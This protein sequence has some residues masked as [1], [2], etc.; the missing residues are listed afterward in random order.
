MRD[1]RRCLWNHSDSVDLDGHACPDD[2]LGNCNLGEV[3]KTKH[4]VSAYCSLGAREW[5][6]D[7]T[8]TNVVALE[9]REIGMLTTQVVRPEVKGISLRNGELTLGPF[10]AGLDLVLTGMRVS[11]DRQFAY[12]GTAKLMGI[13]G[14]SMK[15][16]IEMGGRCPE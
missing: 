2:G 10:Y 6:C 3:N 14:A 4:F 1:L 11:T 12:G 5:S 9:R 7:A 15:S 8:R 16:K 13:G